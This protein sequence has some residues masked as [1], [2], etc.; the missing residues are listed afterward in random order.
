M[1]LRRDYCDVIQ[2]QIQLG[3]RV[4][5]QPHHHHAPHAHP[6]AIPAFSLLRL[7]AVQRLGIAALGIAAVWTFVFWALR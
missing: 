2:S 7:A 1:P 4:A 5:M 3:I 6:P